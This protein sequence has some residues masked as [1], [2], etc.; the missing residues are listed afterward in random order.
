MMQID[1]FT[2]RLELGSSQDRFK[3]RG[4]DNEDETQNQEDLHSTIR[5]DIKEK[6]QVHSTYYRDS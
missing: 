2:E 5:K 4:C 3:S 6:H 1:E